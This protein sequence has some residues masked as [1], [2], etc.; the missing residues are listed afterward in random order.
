MNRKNITLKSIISSQIA[1]SRDIVF[2]PRDY[3]YLSNSK[4]VGN[5][6]SKLVEE[7][8]LVRVG[9]GIYARGK[10]SAYTGKVIPA[11]NLREIALGVMDKIGVKVIPTKAEVD[12]N[13]RISTQVP[14]EFVIGV[15]K[16]VSRKI[17]FGNARIIYE[18]LN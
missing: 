3:A 1:N 2:M 12:Y 9:Y 13:N 5:V 8:Q 4:Q 7:K 15:N 10:I 18:K 17:A 11:A 6:F 16:N 14:D